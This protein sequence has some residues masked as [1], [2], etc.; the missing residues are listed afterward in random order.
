[1]VLGVE[2]AGSSRRNFWVLTPPMKL[3]FLVLP[4][5]TYTIYSGARRFY[6]YVMKNGVKG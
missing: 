4:V 1:M 2:D 3:I 5:F 6:R